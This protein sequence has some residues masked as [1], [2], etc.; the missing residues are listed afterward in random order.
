[1]IVAKATSMGP[2]GEKVLAVISNDSPRI[3]CAIRVAPDG[4]LDYRN[5]VHVPTSCFL[6]C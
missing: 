6:H 3:P 1:M 4:T 2:D 5:Q